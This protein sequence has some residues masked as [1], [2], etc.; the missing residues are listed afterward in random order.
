MRSGNGSCQALVAMMAASSAAERSRLTRSARAH[1]HGVWEG[2]HHVLKE[3]LPTLQER[4]D[5]GEVE[6]ISK[7]QWA[8]LM[9]FRELFDPHYELEMR[10]SRLS[11]QRA[12]R[13]SR[14]TVSEGASD[15]LFNKAMFIDWRRSQMRTRRITEREKL[16]WMRGIKA[17]AKQEVSMWSV[18]YLFQDTIDITSLEKA[19]GEDSQRQK[20]IKKPVDAET[21]VCD[22]DW[23]LVSEASRGQSFLA[24]VKQPDMAVKRCRLAC[25]HARMLHKLPENTAVIPVAQCLKLLHEWWFVTGTSDP[26]VVGES[27]VEEEEETEELNRRAQENRS[28]FDQEKGGEFEA[29][30]SEESMLTTLRGQRYGYM[31]AR[32]PMRLPQ[33]KLQRIAKVK[34]RLEALAGLDDD[35]EESAEEMDLF[36]RS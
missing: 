14:I 15:S 5:V 6:R 24:L 8:M 7:D 3:T 20:Q 27:E 19:L 12:M 35:E 26:G 33:M 25:L 29:D 21:Q 31:F 2:F 9:C 10:I 13:R 16:D 17:T 36:D 18:L 11:F 22:E 30:R 34:R 1:V 32:A 4:M 23:H 28:M